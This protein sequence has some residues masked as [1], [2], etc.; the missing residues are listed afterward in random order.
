MQIMAKH[1]KMDTGN[2]TKAMQVVQLLGV[3][4]NSE[5][6]SGDQP[7]AGTNIEAVQRFLLE[8]G[9]ISM[10][11]DTATLLDTSLLGKPKQ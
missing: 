9:L 10:G 4:R 3:Q 6:L 1:E 8:R 11:A 2:F 5:L 7:A